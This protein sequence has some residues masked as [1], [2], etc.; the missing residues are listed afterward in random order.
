MVKKDF[1]KMTNKEKLTRKIIE[2]IHGCEYEEA[3][4]KELTF[5]CII[6]TNNP[7]FKKDAGK[8]VFCGM[9]IHNDLNF[10]AYFSDGDCEAMNYEDVAKQKY[11]IKIIGLPI[12]IGRV[13]QSLNNSF[14]RSD[15]GYVCDTSGNISY[16]QG[17]IIHKKICEWKLTQPNG[18]ECDLNSQSKETIDSLLKLFTE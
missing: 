7:N 1:Q 4:K 8:H 16:V 10:M 3:V 9:D 5:G 12:T 17:M 11:G 15:E 6:D 13:M 14:P 2:A 18:Q